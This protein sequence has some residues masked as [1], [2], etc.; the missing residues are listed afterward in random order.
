MQLAE[1]V[2]LEVCG[3]FLTDISAEN[4]SKT[5]TEMSWYTSKMQAMLAKNIIS[6]NYW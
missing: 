5:T 1:P 6:H 4:S 2:K 3:T